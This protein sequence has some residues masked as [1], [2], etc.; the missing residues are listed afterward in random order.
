MIVQA[1]ISSV[2][3][4]EVAILAMNS[5]MIRF[6]E[7]IRFAVYEDLDETKVKRAVRRCRA[8]PDTRMKPLSD[9]N[10]RKYSKAKSIERGVLIIINKAGV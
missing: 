5:R 1:K 8:K 10:F 9:E 7:N 2:N 4:I 3:H 6:V